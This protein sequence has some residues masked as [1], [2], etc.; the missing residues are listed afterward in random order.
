MLQ[1]T[2]YDLKII[3]DCLLLQVVNTSNIH[4]KQNINQTNSLIC[5]KKRY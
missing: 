5:Q 4:N 3:F 2:I 1:Q